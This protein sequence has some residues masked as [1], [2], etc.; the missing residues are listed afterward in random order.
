MIRNLLPLAGSLLQ[1]VAAPA[2]G[3]V[4]R[5]LCSSL[6]ELAESAAN[7]IA[8]QKMSP[9]SLAKLVLDDETALPY[10]RLGT[11]MSVL[12]PTPPAA[13]GLTRLGKLR[14]SHVRSP[15]EPPGFSKRLLQR[16]LSLTYWI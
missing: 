15:S 1:R 6:E 8:S 11:E 5:N 13:L 3:A 12:W 16:G 4:F 2:N 10:L 9:D 7:Q 14:L